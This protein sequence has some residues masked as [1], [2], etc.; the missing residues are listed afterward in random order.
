MAALRVIFSSELGKHHDDLL[1]VG[2]DRGRRSHM[3]FDLCVVLSLGTSPSRP[4]GRL[5]NELRARA[6]ERICQPVVGVIECAAVAA[7]ARCVSRKLRCRAEPPPAPN[8]T[9]AVAPADAAR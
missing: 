7:A 6:S 4:A 9:K 3:E 5:R 1:A 8:P 2:S